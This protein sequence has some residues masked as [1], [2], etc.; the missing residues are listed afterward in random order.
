[1]RPWLAW[2]S[3]SLTCSPPIPTDPYL[4]SLIHLKRQIVQE[5][6]LLLP[7]G[8]AS[9]GPCS[10]IAKCGARRGL[11]AFR[12][13]LVYCFSFQ[14]DGGLVEKKK[15]EEKKVGCYGKLR[16][17]ACLGSLGKTVSFK[18]CSTWWSCV[19]VTDAQLQI[20]VSWVG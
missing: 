17:E 12:P 10:R 8:G 5:R 3:P 15:D 2:N 6:Y 14:F 4:P 19:Q 1:M 18:F 7:H 9:H 13:F 16:L 20:N 11:G